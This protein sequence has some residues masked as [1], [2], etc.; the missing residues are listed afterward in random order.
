MLDSASPEEENTSKKIIE[1]PPCRPGVNE[2]DTIPSPTKAAVTSK[3]ASGT[4]KATVVV[5]VVVVVVIV[6]VLLG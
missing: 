2:T 6:I 4:A 3:G 1:A 5:V